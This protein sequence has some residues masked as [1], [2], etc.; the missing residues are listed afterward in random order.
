MKRRTWLKIA[1]GAGAIGS[2]MLGGCLGSGDDTDHRR[3]DSDYRWKY[4][5]GG[6]LDAVSQGTVF[7]R[8]RSDEEAVGNDS[9]LES[10]PEANGQVVALDVETGKLQWTYGGTGELSSYTELTVTDGVYFGYC[11]DDDCIGLYA[12]ERDGEERW[13]SDVGG[14][15]RSPFVVD[16]VIYVGNDNGIVS[17]FDAETGAE[18]WTHRMREPN[19]RVSSSGTVVEVTDTV[20]AEIDSS[21][22]TLDRDGGNALWRYD[23][24]DADEQSILDTAVSNGVAYVVTFER[25]LAVADGDELWR[26]DFEESAVGAGTEITGVT[27]SH[28]FV[29]ARNDRRESRLYA[30]DVTTGERDWMT[31]PIEHQYE[32]YGPQVDVHDE[33]VYIGLERVRALDA[34]TGS[35]RWTGVL[36]SGPVQSVTVVGESVARDHAVFVHADETRLASFAPDGEQTWRGSVNGTIG[37]YLVDEFVFVAT[38]EG[39]YALDGSF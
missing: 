15:R 12:L 14:A 32:E 16:G 37:N 23:V 5:V 27:S 35:E 22:V 19:G 36:D 18:R 31:E 9:V 3:N 20:Y 7:G 8:E 28:L 25:A 34:V 11:G 29:L 24:S 10:G 17:A 21:L 26:W 38:D 1:G 13:S 30:F 6:E 33:V 39:I 2:S 4:D